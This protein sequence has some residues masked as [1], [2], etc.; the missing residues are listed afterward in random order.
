MHPYDAQSALYTAEKLQVKL[1][2]ALIYPSD[3]TST[4]PHDLKEKLCLRWNGNVVWGIIMARQKN[5]S[6]VTAE[7]LHHE[8]SGL[9]IAEPGMTP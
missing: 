2:N 5:E 3:R 6:F 1:T 7:N 4:L 8:N 9:I